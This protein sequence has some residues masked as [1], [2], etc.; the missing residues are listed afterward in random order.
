MGIIN[1]LLKCIWSVV[2]EK[3]FLETGNQIKYEMDIRIVLFN[4][5]QTTFVISNSKG[6]T[7]LLINELSVV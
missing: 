7:K 4:Y 6:P 1:E 3:V 5:V 2:Y